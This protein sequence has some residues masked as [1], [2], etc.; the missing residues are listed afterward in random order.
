VVDHRPW[1]LPDR[2]WFMGQTWLN[3]L[4]AHW[5]VDVEALRPVVPPQLPIQTAEGSAWL[6]ITPFMVR[7]LRIRGTPPPPLLS[8]FPE[9]NVRTYVSVGGKPGIYFFSLD[10]DS[11]SAV[12]TAR[13][14]YRLPYFRSKISVRKERGSFDYRVRRISSDGPPASFQAM[15]AP[16]GD[17]SPPE[18]GSLPHW[19]SER[20]CLYTLD[21]RQRILRAE[22]H[23]PPW[24]LQ[25]ARAEIEMNTMANHLDVSLHGGPLLH[26]S[27]RQDVVL[28][29]PRVV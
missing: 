9:I 27:A 3:L 6:G 17:A 24:P 18:P 29:R 28:W 8:R 23:H 2:R 10:A 21:E 5:P 1:R 25:E 16:V 13:R 26:F 7:G 12:F 14:I 20:Y 22:I 19:L 11:L 4:F 15:Y